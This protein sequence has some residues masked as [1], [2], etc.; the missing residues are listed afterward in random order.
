[1]SKVV[2]YQAQKGLC[3]QCAAVLYGLGRLHAGEL[4][5]QIC[6]HPIWREKHWD[7]ARNAPKWNGKGKSPYEL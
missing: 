3:A 4:L 1:M 6:Y 5:C 7:E 2:L